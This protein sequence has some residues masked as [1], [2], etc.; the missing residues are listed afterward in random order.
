M[1]DFVKYSI[2]H[3]GFDLDFNKIDWFH[4]SGRGGEHA[5]VH[6]PSGRWN[7]LSATPVD[8]VSVQGHVIDVKAD[9]AHVLITEN[10]LKRKGG[11]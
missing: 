5:S 4:H 7:D 8:G 11:I 2:L 3:T 6:A 9:A 1:G 10:T